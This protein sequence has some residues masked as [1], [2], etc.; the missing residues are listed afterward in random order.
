MEYGE[1]KD[2]GSRIKEKVCRPEK[3]FQFL[4]CGFFL[5]LTFRFVIFEIVCSVAGDPWSLRSSG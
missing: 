2:K 5:G 4:F 1:W 3:I